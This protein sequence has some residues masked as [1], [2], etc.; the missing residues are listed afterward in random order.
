MGTGNQTQI[1]CKSCAHSLTTELPF[2]PQT[3]LSVCLV[4]VCDERWGRLTP[5][6]KCSARKQLL[7]SV[8]FYTDGFQG[9][10]SHHTACV[11]N[12][13]PAGPSHCI[14][15]SCCLACVANS[16]P[17]GPSL[18]IVFSCCLTTHIS[19]LILLL[20]SWQDMLCIQQMYRNRD[21]LTRKG[22]M[23]NL[24]IKSREG[25]I[26]CKKESHHHMF[27]SFVDG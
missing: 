10:N 23:E 5:Q 25:S 3:L 21:L 22:E 11:A 16:S 17:A 4:P 18:C 15:F 20:V 9:L 12:S 2:Q 8:L 26:N 24:R 6:H 13:S 27:S 1:L 19:S 14:V 7:E